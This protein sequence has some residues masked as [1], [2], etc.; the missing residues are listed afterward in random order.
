LIKTIYDEV[1]IAL[2]ITFVVFTE[3]KLEDLLIHLDTLLEI[4]LIQ[5]WRFQY[6]P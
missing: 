5:A 4:I 2:F 6:E 3:K 1:I